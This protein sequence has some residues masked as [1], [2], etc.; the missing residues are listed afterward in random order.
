MTNWHVY[1]VQWTT[2]SIAWAVDGQIYETQT[3]WWSSST[4]SNTVN[5]PYPAPFD[6]PFFVIMNLAV[7][8]TFPGSPNSSTPF[9]GDMQVDYVRVYDFTPLL[10]LSTMKT[11][12]HYQLI[13]PTN[14][15]CRLQTQTQL[16][17]NWVTLNGATSPYT[18]TL[19]LQG[20]VFF[21]LVSP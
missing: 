7:G 12:G 10:Q 4:T 17:G 2:N 8:G 5:N 13:W 3:N 20:G 18:P 16:G 6:Q 21:R 11:N 19:P 14:I 15:V 1:T 9:P